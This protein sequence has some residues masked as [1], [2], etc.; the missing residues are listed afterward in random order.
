MSAASLKD[1]ETASNP[2]ALDSSTLHPISFRATARQK[3][4][5]KANAGDQSVSAYVLEAALKTH[6]TSDR[7]IKVEMAA[8]ILGA[9]GEF[10]VFA[11]LSLLANSAKNGALPMTEELEAELRSACVLVIAIR[12]DLIEALGIKVED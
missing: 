11:S 6:R 4:T 9:L 1:F 2:P 7:A 8:R 10:G 5:I 12:H 3:A